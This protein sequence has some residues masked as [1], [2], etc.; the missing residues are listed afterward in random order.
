MV[1]HVLAVAAQ[2]RHDDRDMAVAN[3]EQDAPHAG[4]ADHG[5][6]GVEMGDHLVEAHERLGYRRMLR[7][8]AVT[9]LDDQVAGRQCRDRV[10]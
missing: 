8:A 2:P 3:G 4:V 6:C 5:I 7:R 10:Q 1:V 9:V